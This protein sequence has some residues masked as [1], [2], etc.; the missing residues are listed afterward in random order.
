MTKGSGRSARFGGGVTYG[1]RECL[2]KDR[3]RKS[4]CASSPDRHGSTG[5]RRA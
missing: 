4:C 5:L 2:R 1:Y 3:V